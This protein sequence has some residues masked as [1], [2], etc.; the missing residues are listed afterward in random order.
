MCRPQ[1]QVPPVILCLMMK[2]LKKILFALYILAMLT[3]GGATIIEKYRGSGYVSAHVYG[4]WW[5]SLLWAMLTATAVFYFIKTRVRRCSIVALH[6]SFVV[7][8]AGAFATHVSSKSGRIHL[9]K[10][11]TVTTYTADDGRG[12]DMVRKLPFGLK[13]DAFEIK[14]H[15]GT[16]AAADYESVFTVIDNGKMSEGRVSMNNIFSYRSVRLYQSSYDSDMRGSVLSM[17]SDPYG[18]PITYSGY[19]LLFVSL[20]WMLADPKGRYR[21]L[22]RSGIAAKGTVLLLA[23]M[24]LPGKAGAAPVLP[25]ETARKFGELYILYNNRV[26]PLQTFAIDFT[27]KLYGK[28]SYKGYT[29]EQVLTGFIFW[30]DEWSRE[31]ILKV[32]RGAMR[33]A[34][35]LPEYCSVSTFFNDV[36]GGYIIGPYVREYYNGQNDAFHKQVAD[37][38]SRL[39]MVM[40]LR[41]GIPLKV[42]PFT[43]RGK[44]TWYSPTDKITDTA[45][46]TL[47]RRYIKDVFSLIYQEARAASYTN[48]DRIA[49]K[50]LQ[51]QKKNAGR[52]LPSEL[53]TKAER[54]YNAVPF[55]TILF[56]IN[57]TLGFI[58]LFCNIVF[59]TRNPPAGGQGGSMFLSFAAL[60]LCLGLRWIISGNVPMAN[61]YETMLL[62]AWLIMLV[63]LLTCRR[64]SFIMGFGFLMSGFF[65]LVSHINMMN[66]GITHIMP[67]LSSPLLCIHV[68]VIMMSFALLSLTFICSLTAIIMRMAGGRI[69]RSTKEKTASLRLLSELFLYPALAA[70]GFGIFIGAV[71]ANVSWG[72]YWS[73]DAKEVWALITFM[74]YGVAVHR[75]SLPFLRRDMCWHVYVAAA[76]LSVIMTYFGVNYFLG[77]MHSYA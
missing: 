44:T 38:D 18:I 43:N 22:L 35:Q 76:F 37:V 28:G 14:Y 55:A 12:G 50:M 62:M 3:M 53:Q 26:C 57:L 65:L 4:S 17:N 41:R 30:G 29:P 34:L 45:V 46:D 47:H 51:Y 71:W 40:E 73:W 60:T 31:P 23:A 36:M 68:S 13:L 5:F 49:A 69:S 19:G 66:P 72:N 27:K 33:E 42:F 74:V 1:G 10:G 8:L 7:I 24:A 63:S 15:E 59:P 75:G 54:I 9:R 21:H 20:L 77:G 56:I 32:K 16:E 2:H 39:M 11:E 61:G 67:V 64:S 70:L 25:E 58:I 48:I 52:S 6:L